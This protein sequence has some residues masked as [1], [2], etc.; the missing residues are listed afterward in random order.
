MKKQFVAM[1]VGAL[2]LLRA[3]REPVQRTRRPARRHQPEGRR[4][5]AAVT[6]DA[7]TTD[8]V[9]VP[10]GQDLIVDFGEINSSTGEDW[11]II[12]EPDSAVLSPGQS[13]SETIGDGAPGS[14]NRFSYRFVAIEAGTTQ[15]EFQY[16]FQ[17]SVPDLAAEHE[18]IVIDVTV[19]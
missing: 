3:H 9:T 18:T 1:I 13:Q 19:E 5:S 4:V 12:S 6:V 11:V 8:S 10:A 14:P 17:G 2:P 7:F 15:I 16:Q